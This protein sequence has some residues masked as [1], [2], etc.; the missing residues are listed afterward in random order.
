MNVQDRIVL[1]IAKNALMIF[2][3][4]IIE[5]ATNMIVKSCCIIICVDTLTNIAPK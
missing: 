4:I 1:I 5:F 3:F 2:T